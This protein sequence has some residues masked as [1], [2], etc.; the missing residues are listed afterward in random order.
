[1]CLEDIAHHLAAVSRYSG[2]TKAPYSVAE[3]SVIVS[4]YVPP[5]HALE[6]LL[7][8]ATEAYLGD[9]I[10]PIKRL[11]GTEYGEV[12]HRLAAVIFEKFGVV[13]TPESRAAVKA[14][15]DRIIQ[16][17]VQALMLH[18]EIFQTREWL[19]GVVPLGAAIACLSPRA[20]EHVFYQ[21]FLELTGAS[22][23]Y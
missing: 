13:S 15:D 10:R 22:R 9:I 4:L 14:I 1:M 19:Q 8:D 17:E 11:F 6:G 21:R 5:E 3:H 16:D 23:A 20:A 18:P 2:A 12:E 7:H